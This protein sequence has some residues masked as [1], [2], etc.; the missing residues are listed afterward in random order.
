MR[1]PILT[2]LITVAVLSGA[3]L[4]SAGILTYTPI[5]GDEDSGIST[6]LQYTAKADFFAPEGGRVINGVSFL[7]TGLTGTG[8]ILAG[9]DFNLS[10]G[11]QPNNVLGE[12]GGLV[13]D[14]FYGPA[15]GNATL[16]LT[17]LTVG[18]EYVTSF[19]NRAW[20]EPGGRYSF[21]RAS[22]TP[23]GVFRI[24]QNFSGNGNGNVLRYV[25][26]AT[27]DT[28]TFEFD[29]VINADTFHHYGF[30]N[31]VNNEAILPLS[32]A[33]VAP[34]ISTLAAPEPAA[35]VTAP[36]VSNND[37]LQTQLAAAS[38]SGT[39]AEEGTGGVAALTNGEFTAGAGNDAYFTP[40][41]GASV[42]FD[43][44]VSANTLGY[45]ITSVRGFGGWND[46]GRDRQNYSLYYSVVGSSEFELLGTVDFDLDLAAGTASTITS[47][48]DTSLTGVDAIRVDFLDPQE[49]GHAGYGE[50]DVIG[51]ATVPEP[52]SLLLLTG[53]IP[54]LLRR[55]RCA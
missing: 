16:T 55:R 35:P 42:T 33:P 28:Q 27:A 32:G 21:I 10:G 20:G 37:L 9:P 43:L 17:D 48:F 4:A 6:Q 11:D 1:P 46:N 45:D 25:F 36:G 3:H 13:T 7:D 15:D 50:F 30:T 54:L 34:R 24:D 19:Y 51:I 39:V 22:D 23:E 29:A 26:T 5:T 52:S 38:V 31:A 8:Y 47:I 49:N 2:T 41:V 40:T 18:T 53:A 44:D 14:F 12:T